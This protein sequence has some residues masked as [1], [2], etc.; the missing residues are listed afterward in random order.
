MATNKLIVSRI[1]LNP[2]SQKAKNDMSN[3]YD[4]HKSLMTAFPRNNPQ[5]NC[6]MLFRIEDC[7]NPES[8]GMPIL[9]QSNAYPNW[10]E[11]NK[12][13][14]Y[15]FRKP[16][17]KEI[18]NIDL[19]RDCEYRFLLRANP[20]RRSRDNAKIVG[21]HSNVEL[22]QWVNNKGLK[23]GFQVDENELVIK[24]LPSLHASK[25]EG[26][27]EEKILINYVEYSGFLQVTKI[28]ELTQ[29]LF[30]GVGRGTDFGCGL[31]SLAST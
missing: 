6:S 21:L 28:N 27:A 31:L 19:R 11:L 12:V 10:S 22:I 30:T 15:F 4:L 7:L 23:H 25:I 2:F 13:A 26:G 9:I 17:T 24:K 14:G 20:A 5:D 8:E 3:L 1:H 16:I 18:D 29:A